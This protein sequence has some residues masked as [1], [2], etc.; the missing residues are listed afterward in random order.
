MNAS[1]SCDI[2]ICKP[3]T[4]CFYFST[5]FTCVPLYINC[6]G[7][8]NNDVTKNL[9]PGG[10]GLNTTITGLHFW[11]LVTMFL[12]KWLTDKYVYRRYS[13]MAMYDRIIN[14]WASF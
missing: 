2:K 1:L 3:L 12:K 7:R 11:A 9:P 13:S 4:I 5:A 6:E 10:G 8:S 14:I